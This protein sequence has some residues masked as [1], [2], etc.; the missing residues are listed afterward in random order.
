MSSIQMAV[1]QG[2]PRLGDMES[3]GVA[4]ATSI[5]FSVVSGGLACIVGAVI[6]GLVMPQFRNHH[7]GEIDEVPV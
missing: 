5:E 1:V 7:A 6:I 2:G 3:G 4:T